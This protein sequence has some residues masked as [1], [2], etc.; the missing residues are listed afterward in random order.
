VFPALL[1]VGTPLLGRERPVARLALGQ[2]GAR[3]QVLQAGVAQVRQALADYRGGQADA[4]GLEQGDVGPRA[5]AGVGAH[6]QATVFVQDQ[7]GFERV[8]LLLA[9]IVAPLSF[10]GRSTSVSVAST[11]T[12][13]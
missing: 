6:D 2:A 13:R 3:G 12:A 1:L 5:A 10:W 4:A 8:A 11:I 7:L 9:A